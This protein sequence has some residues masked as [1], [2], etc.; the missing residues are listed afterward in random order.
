MTSLPATQEIVL[1]VVD[2]DLLAVVLDHGGVEDADRPDRVQIGYGGVDEVGVIDRVIGGGVD[3]Y[4]RSLP[5]LVP[6]DSEPSGLSRPYRY[7]R[8]FQVRFGLGHFVLAVVKNRG[9]E[10]RVSATLKHSL[11]EVV[12]LSGA[13]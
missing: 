6:S 8:S 7:P 13:A 1:R 10:D 4:G 12:E 11:G 5:L 3:E 9:A 2:V